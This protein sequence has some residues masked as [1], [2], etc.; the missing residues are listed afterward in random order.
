MVDWKSVRDQNN[1]KVESKEKERIRKLMPPP[2]DGKIYVDGAFEGGGV[3]GLVFLGALRLFDDLGF[4]WRNVVGTSAGA[5]SA[6]LISAEYSVDALEEII[7]NTNYMDRF[8]CQKT[9]HCIPSV[10][11]STDLLSLWRLLKSGVA[12]ILT[13]KRGMYSITPFK[14]WLVEKLEEKEI[15]NFDDLLKKGIQNQLKVVASN[16]SSGKM[17]ILPDDLPQLSSVAEAVSMSACLPLFFEPEEFQGQT[18]VDGGIF[19]RFPIWIFDISEERI[20]KGDYPHWPTFGLR[21]I[22]KKNKPDN[23]RNLYEL[24]RAILQN[25]G[26]ARDEYDAEHT[27]KDRIIQIDVSPLNISSTQFTLAD[28]DKEKLYCLGYQRAKEFFN[29]WD[30][31]KHLRRRGFAPITV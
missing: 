9:S 30:W 2:S 16:L 27:W 21:I 28:K 5:I 20:S 18:I 10:D 12:L 8:L 7:G 23:I 19:S 15:T 3:W 4:T 6:A 11:L 14:D 1:L 25:A 13:G 26:V 31:N 17:L 24:G 29:T 22:D